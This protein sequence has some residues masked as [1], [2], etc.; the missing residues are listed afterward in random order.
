MKTITV[1]EHI[2]LDGVIQSP[3]SSIEDDSDG[4][5]DGG[6]ISNY[7]DEMIH[8]EIVK[9]MNYKVD[10][11]LGRKTY[12]IWSAYWPYHDDIWQYK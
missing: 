7:S 11:L 8:D 12:N 9:I 10:Y 5:N 1:V 4:F 6:W 2:T 3:G